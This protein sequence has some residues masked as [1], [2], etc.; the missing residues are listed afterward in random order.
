MCERCEELQKTISRYRE[1]L[2]QRFDP[3][4]ESRIKELIT[5]LE[6]QK[7]AMHQGR[8]VGGLFH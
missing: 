7:D 1:L 2:R 6:R 3:L 4:T 8:S 5:D